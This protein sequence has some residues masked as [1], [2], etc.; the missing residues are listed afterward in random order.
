[1]TP[2]DRDGVLVLDGQTTQALAAVRSL[3]RA[4]YRVLVASPRARPL[5]AWSRYC[6]GRFH[7]AGETPEAY[8]RVRDWAR[9]RGVRTV[10]P[11]TERSCIL[12]NAD[13]AAW[14]A[15]G[16]VLGCAPAPLLERAFDKAETMRAA[17]ACGVRTPPTRL[18]E[19]LDEAHA[20][21]RELG[22]PC[23]VKQRSSNSW[24]GRV[25]QP[26]AGVAY[27]AEASQLEAAVLARR[28]GDAWPLIEGFVPGQGKGVFAVCDHGR[29]VAW[30]AHERLRDV[31]PSGS[32]SSLRRSAALDPRLTEPAERLLRALAWHGPVMVE[33]RDDGR[34]AP[35]LI[36]INGRFWGS[37]QLAISAGVDFPRLWMDV[38]HGAA[39]PPQGAYAEGVTVRWLWGDVKRFLYVLAGP[40]RGYP[41]RYP[42]RLQGVRELLG[43]QPPNTRLEAWQPGDPWPAVGE[44]VQGLDDLRRVALRSARAAARPSPSVPA[45]QPRRAAVSA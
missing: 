19:S 20:A 33:F 26:N 34:D 8:A 10:L 2:E 27:V 17:A 21:A 1:M 16:F 41:G 29:A 14:E 18:P 5:A 22:Y 40:P 31:R 37:L 36:E 11:M 42:T 32:G 3:G 25:F 9:A 23:I 15:A 4:G 38:V 45:G 43:P 44:V 6:R 39:V 28:R 12:G 7:L 30:F 24:D 13:R 35:Y